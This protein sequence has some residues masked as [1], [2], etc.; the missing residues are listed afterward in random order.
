MTYHLY[1]IPS[2][3][4]SVIY[5]LSNKS[6]HNITASKYPKWLTYSSKHCSY[7]CH[8]SVMLW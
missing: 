3:E 5:E 2:N 8:H 1:E 4:D 6:L 7:T